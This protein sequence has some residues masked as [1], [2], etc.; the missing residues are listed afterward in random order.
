MFLCKCTWT[1]MKLERAPPP[2]HPPTTPF[3][4][5]ERLTRSF[6]NDILTWYKITLLWSEF[7][8]YQKITFTAVNLM[9]TKGTVDLYTRFFFCTSQR[10]TISMST[11]LHNSSPLNWLYLKMKIFKHL[12]FSALFVCSPYTFNAPV[13]LGVLVFN[14]PHPSILTD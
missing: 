11:L 12:P 8:H 10:H 4:N 14:M 6:S 13:V 5:T 1:S 3:F 7:F 9:N 2:P